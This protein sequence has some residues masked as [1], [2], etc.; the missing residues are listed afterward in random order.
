M[1]QE[2]LWSERS[3]F[4]SPI[5]A[6][7]Q[8]PSADLTLETYARVPYGKE[9]LSS[10]DEIEPRELC[11]DPR[12]RELDRVLMKL[13]VMEIAG[14][15]YIEEYIRYQYRSY[16]RPNTIR[17]SYNALAAFGRFVKRLEKSDI[18]K[19]NKRDLEAFVEHE[20]ERGLKLSTV[21]T[22]VAV[23]K[24]F[25]RFLME[26][27][28][29]GEDVFPW[30]L[31]IKM[32][33][34][35]PRC[36]DPEDVDRL[37]AAEGRVRDRAMI[38]V[39]LRT[40]MRIGELL[41]TRVRDLIIEEQ[42]ILIFEAEK[43][44]RGR[45][46]YFSTDAKDALK[47]WLDERDKSEEYLFYGRRRRPLTYPA[48]RI[49]FMRYLEKAGLSHKGYTLHCLRH[50]Y[51]TDLLN[52][53]MALECLEKLLG[54]RSLEVTR[55]YARLTDKSR[56]EAYFKAMAIIE[57]S[58]RD[59]YQQCDRELQALLEKTQLLPSHDQELPEHP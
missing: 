48:A 29:I 37:I 26:R 18:K 31:K 41:S 13:S 11:P 30:K 59:G 50:T 21:K 52:A 55:R 49:V 34:S 36:M 25:L 35:L 47:A 27:G 24:A 51:A 16:C 7:E 56:E 58:Q 5:R 45:V 28:V 4:S 19:V 46:V 2:A 14:K 44:Q 22:R 3:N 39:L 53:G 54:H 6:P 38:M 42:K 9:L 12:R 20:Q 33:E 57:R 10:F 23:L 8:T 40:G 43:N 17:N 1:T 15:E 32:P